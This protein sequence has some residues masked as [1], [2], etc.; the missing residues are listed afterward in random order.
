MEAFPTSPPPALRLSPSFLSFFCCCVRGTFGAA[1]MNT[2]RKRSRLGCRGGQSSAIARVPDPS[3][4]R[5]CC[6]SR[7]L[8]R[9][10]ATPRHT[11]RLLVPP[12]QL[13]KQSMG[14]RCFH[15]VPARALPAHYQSIINLRLRARPSFDNSIAGSAVAIIA[16]A[17]E[18]VRHASHR[19]PAAS[20]TRSRTR[21]VSGSN[22]PM[23]ALRRNAARIEWAQP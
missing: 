18:R 7:P 11:A 19:P 4:G 14:G 21:Y 17:A 15:G 9:R 1:R 10:H 5:A 6:P 8:S 13:R 23:Q 12:G 22:S 2:A 20:A 16:A 3:R